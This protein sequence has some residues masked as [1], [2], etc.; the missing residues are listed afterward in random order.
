MKRAPLLPAFLQAAHFLRI[1]IDLSGINSIERIVTADA[2]IPD[3]FS[4]FYI[5]EDE[6]QTL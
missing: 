3:T 6:K 1:G 2:P 4:P 5:V